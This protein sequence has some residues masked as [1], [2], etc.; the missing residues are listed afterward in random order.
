MYLLLIIVIHFNLFAMNKKGGFGGC[1]TWQ[2]NSEMG[3]DDEEGDEFDIVILKN[4]VAQ[5]R[6]S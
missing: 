5:V 6:T 1:V 4:L 3:E 2:F